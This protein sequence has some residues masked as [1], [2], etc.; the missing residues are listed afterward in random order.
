MPLDDT[1]LAAREQFGKQ[2]HRYAKGHILENVEDVA[3]AVAQMALPEHADVLDVACGAGHTG[4][5][6]A[7]LG[8]SVTL[9]DIAQPMLDRATELAASRGLTVKTHRH[10]AEVLPYPDASFDLVTC[11]VAAHHFSSPQD[12]VRES[13]RAL[14]P[15]G[16]FLL[17]DGSV[18][19]DQPEAE[20]WLHWVEKYRD[21]SHGGFLTPRRW[22]GLCAASGLEL[23]SCALTSLKQPDLE[24]YF[25]TAATSPENREKVLDLVRN[26][27][28]HA[29]ELFKL[30]EEEG[31]IVWWWQRVTVVAR[32]G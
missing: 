7:S 8:H 3:E 17:I 28:V 11:R 15:G 21:P 4:L 1:Q 25:E 5:Y 2:S 29:R 12:F 13:A 31:K 27:P 30:R 23:I 18:A 16:Y 20:E 6:L 32:K 24:W 9:A 14:K 10:T 26:A 19:D 22:S